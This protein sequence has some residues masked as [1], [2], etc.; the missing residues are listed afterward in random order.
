MPYRI[1]NYIDD[2]DRPIVKQL[3][4]YY[5]HCELELNFTQQTMYGKTSA[6][7]HFLRFSGIKRL[8]DLDNEMVTGYIKSQ[9]AAGLKPRTINNRLKHLLAMVRY[10]RDIEELEI[11]NFKD[12]KIKKQ[13][14][15]SP[16]KRAF[17]RE[18]I[19]EALRYADREAWLVIKICFD[20]GLRI[21]ELHDLRLEDINGHQVSVLG[22]GR[23]R[24]FVIL[25]DEVVVRLQDWIKRENITDW[26]W[27]SAGR[28]VP[29]SCAT[30]RRIIRAP[31]DAAGVIH[32]CPHELRHSYAT[33]L[34]HLG[35]ETRSIQYGLGHS[36]EKITEMYLHD[37]DSS[38]LQ[39]LYHLKYSAPSPEIR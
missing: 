21:Q 20:C 32:L 29:K 14:E 22:K 8:E 17:P 10:Y 16:N 23:K 7:N 6:L 31:F 5:E 2:L 3:I 1:E 33:D 9:T 36:S 19:Y 39:E 38:A 4:Q 28:R 26:L 11:P 18:V 24:R 37:L 34:K 27:P 12:R 25:S 15:E 13:H 30:M 35:A